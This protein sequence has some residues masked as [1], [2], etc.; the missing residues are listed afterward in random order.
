MGSTKTITISES[1]YNE[2]FESRILLRF[3][4]SGCISEQTR[5]EVLWVV[6][7]LSRVLKGLSEIKSNSPFACSVRDYS[8]KEAIDTII[9]VILG[10]AK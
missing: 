3:L 1:E 7:D 8:L 4:R 9:K 2:L 5:Q 6:D 10:E